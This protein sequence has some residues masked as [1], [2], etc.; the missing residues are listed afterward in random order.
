MSVLA[1]YADGDGWKVAL[2]TLSAERL[3]S[4]AAPTAKFERLAALV[5]APAALR[6][7]PA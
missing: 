6:F 5:G 2:T 1:S 3:V 7:Y 4:G